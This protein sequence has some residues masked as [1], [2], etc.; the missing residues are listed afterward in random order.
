MRRKYFLWLSAAAIVSTLLAGCANP[1]RAFDPNPGGPT[2]VIIPARAVDSNLPADGHFT[3]QAATANKDVT[4]N[5]WY[6]DGTPKVSLVS[7][8][9]PVIN[10]R[11]EVA[12]GLNGQ[13]QTFA[14]NATQLWQGFFAQTVLPAIGQ[15]QTTRWQQSQQAAQQPSRTD[16]LLEELLKRLPPAPTPGMVPTQP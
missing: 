2:T 8:A 11:G 14:I 4:L 5:A 10:A 1:D 6:P 12:M 7:A 3:I 15:Y 16:V 9:S 13:N